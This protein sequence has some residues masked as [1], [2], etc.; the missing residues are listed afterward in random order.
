MKRLIIRLI[1]FLIPFILLAINYVLVTK[2]RDRSGDL[3]RVGHRFFE[4]GYHAKLSPVTEEQYVK[5]IIIDSLPDSIYILCIGD[6][7]SNK[8]LSVQ[9]WN[10]YTGEV[11]NQQ[12]INIPPSNLSPATIA[13]SYLTICPDDKLPKVII[14]ET[15]ERESIPI[16]SSIDINHPEALDNIKYMP[17]DAFGTSTNFFRN[18]I[19]FYQ[20]KL[21]MNVHLVCSNLNKPVFSAK[22][23]ESKLLCYYQD[24]THFTDNEVRLAVENLERLH[25]LAERRGVKFFYLICPNKSNVYWPYIRENDRKKFYNILDRTTTFDTLPYVYSPLLMLRERVS[26]GEK[27]VFY[28]DDSHWPPKTAKIVGEELANFI[29]KQTTILNN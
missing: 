6:S 27:D 1:I 15:V 24:T 10:E 22:G 25:N 23:D 13:L 16:L 5:D 3:G 19:E 14:M 20:R 2:T 9:R 11:L 8:L 28:C 29:L 4:K 12:I 18:A 26:Q 21:G 17:K 7:F